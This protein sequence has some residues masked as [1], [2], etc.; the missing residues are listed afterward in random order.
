MPHITQDEVIGSMVLRRPGNVNSPLMNEQLA[1]L[2]FEP[3]GR[4]VLIYIP[5]VVTVT[6]CTSKWR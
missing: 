1:A 6:K 5:G 3:L 4:K 2:R